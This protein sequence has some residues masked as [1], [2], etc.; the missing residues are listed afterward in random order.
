MESPDI[1]LW[2]F[3][4]GGAHETSGAGPRACSVHGRDGECPARGADH[5]DSW[6]GW[7]PSHEAIV[8]GEVR[9][10]GRKPEPEG[11]PSSDRGHLTKQLRAASSSPNPDDG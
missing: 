2:R 5:R 1:R 8:P 4:T 6:T 3:A 10:R 9:N 11:Q 7:Q